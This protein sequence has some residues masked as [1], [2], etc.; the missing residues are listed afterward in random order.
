MSAWPLVAAEGKSYIPILK[1]HFKK[2]GTNVFKNQ[3]KKHFEQIID[4]KVFRKYFERGKKFVKK[5]LEE[6]L[7]NRKEDKKCRKPLE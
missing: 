5:F 3:E 6:K 7:L 2:I 4:N 1:K